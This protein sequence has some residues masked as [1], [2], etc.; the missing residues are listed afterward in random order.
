MHDAVG[1]RCAYLAER[2]EHR[3]DEHVALALHVQ[4]RGRQ[5]DARRPPRSGQHQPRDGHPEQDHLAMLGVGCLGAFARPRLQAGQEPPFA[6]RHCRSQDARV[7]RWRQ[8]GQRRARA[9][10]QRG[11]RSGYARSMRLAGAAMRL[12]A[13]IRSMYRSWSPLP[14]SAM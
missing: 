7:H 10:A 9:L 3:L 14:L 6:A 1:W 5:E 4:K 12:T 8:Y 13:S 2:R 11:R